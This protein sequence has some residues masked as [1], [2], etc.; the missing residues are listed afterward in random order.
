MPAKESQAVRLLTSK[1]LGLGGGPV[2]PTKRKVVVDF[3][4]RTKRLTQ[5]ELETSTAE[6]PCSETSH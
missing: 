3:V 4:A 5:P 6:C 1:P 2:R